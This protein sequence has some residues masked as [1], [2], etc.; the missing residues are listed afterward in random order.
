MLRGR[1]RLGAILRLE[2]R[3]TSF[4]ARDVLTG[5]EIAV[6]LVGPSGSADERRHLHEIW[7]RQLSLPAGGV[8]TLLDF[9]QAG[10][11]TFATRRWVDGPSLYER[12]EAGH[13]PTFADIRMIASG[14]FAAA[15]ELHAIGFVHGN[16]ST[17]NVIFDTA[18]RPIQLVLSE[19]G[20][21]TTALTRSR[22]AG[23][24]IRAGGQ[25]SV[26]ADVY[27]LGV[28]LF[29]CLGEPMAGRFDPETAAARLNEETGGLA[30][31]L[32][33]VLR[34][35]AAV[36]P[37]RRYRDVEAASVAF[38][39]AV[40]GWEVALSQPES[41]PSGPMI[42][43]TIPV[44]PEEA[45][46]A[47]ET[48]AAPASGSPAGTAILPAVQPEAEPAPPAIEEAAP[49]AAPAVEETTPPDAEEAPAAGPTI[50]EPPA[51]E[52]PATPRETAILELPALET[53][54]GDASLDVT[55]PVEVPKDTAAIK[56]AG[57][58]AGAK[59]EWD[60]DSPGTLPLELAGQPRG[61]H[62]LRVSLDGYVAQ[63][64]TIVL[65]GDLSLEL[66]LE[67]LPA[68]APVAAEPP[69]IA[70]KPTDAGLI[71][72]LPAAAE[73]PV[74]GPP[75]RIG[76]AIRTGFLALGL[77]FLGLGIVLQSTFFLM[78][79]MTLV[80]GAVGALLTA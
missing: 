24:E 37:E 71:S 67:P 6:R 66:A 64:L 15:A 29:E 63:E 36:D 60:G 10:E 12:L 17:T 38:L 7:Q 1:Y 16:I 2:A 61:T 52:P 35:M 53:S 69:V 40:A 13:R 26:R 46:P 50:E 5:Q 20:L 32:S 78:I 51:P 4:R 65:T 19:P 45:P 47:I 44:E 22:Y 75:G 14:L 68:A 80:L 59:V 74:E 48:A 55:V 62:R 31:P 54:P 77:A 49:A 73:L 3:S 23:V 56:L 11:W 27:S 41:L 18:V 25:P 28:I 43:R 58:P 42:A 72:P 34:R 39:S 8:L 76:W 21:R 33:D 9:D 57:T 70:I 30:K 79:G